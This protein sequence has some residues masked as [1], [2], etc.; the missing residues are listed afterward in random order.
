MGNI[1]QSNL[2]PST[3]SD[4]RP[5]SSLVLTVTPGL[6]HPLYS[7]WTQSSLIPCTQCDP[8]P[9]SSLVLNVTPVLPHPLYSTWPQ[10]SLIPCTQCDPSPPSSLVLNVTPVLPHPLYSMWRIYIYLSLYRLK[11]H[12]EVRTGIFTD[13]PVNCIKHFSDP[14]LLETC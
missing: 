7:M 3:Q 10:S 8:S 1:P 5:P 4:P 14:T 2:I 6:P 9:P 11:A 12:G 13:M